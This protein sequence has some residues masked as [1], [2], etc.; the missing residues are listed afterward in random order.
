MEAAQGHQRQRRATHAGTWYDA[1]SSKLSGQIRRW[2]QRSTKVCNGRVKA[3][4][5]PHAGLRFSGSTAACA[6][7]QIDPSQYSRVFLLGPSHYKYFPGVALPADKCNSYLTPLGDLPLDSEAIQALRLTG[8]FAEL[9]FSEDE[10][11]HSIELMLPFLRHVFKEDV[12]IVP[13]VVG[14]LRGR[15]D[16]QKFADLLL[17]YFLEEL[18]GLAAAKGEQGF[19]TQ[20]IAYSQ[21]DSDVAAEAARALSLK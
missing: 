11:E 15:D 14:D 13:M 3:L 19:A 5:C 6:W 7:K 4:I 10:E 17:K 2:L 20:L 21:L 1:D 18:V 9:S 8:A 16:C 12:K